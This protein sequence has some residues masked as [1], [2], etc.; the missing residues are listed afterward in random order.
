MPMLIVVGL[1]GGAGV[2]PG[3]VNCLLPQLEE[4][5]MRT[6]PLAS[7]LLAGVALAT[8]AAAI[9]PLATDA[10][11]HVAARRWAPPGAAAGP[12]A[13]ESGPP[14]WVSLGPFGGNVLAVATSPA[15]SGLVLAAVD[16]SGGGS[17]LYRSTDGGESWQPVTGLGFIFV[18]DVEFAADGT[19][20][21]A[22]SSHLQTSVDGGLNWSPITNPFNGSV[23][24]VAFEPA[25][26]ALWLGLG[27]ATFGATTFVIRSPDGGD[28]WADRTP[29]LPT[30]LDCTALALEPG[31]PATVYAG[32]SGF[33]G[34][35]ALWV[36]PD[37][38]VT[39]FDRTAGL[40]AV[41]IHRI[42]YDGARAVVAGGA[43]FGSQ[44]FGLYASDDDGMSW[45]PLH[46]GTWP[47]LYTFGLDIDPN[48]PSVL[49]VATATAGIFRSVDGGAEWAFGVAGTAGVSFNAVRYAP[50][51]SSLVLAGA[52][53]QGVFRSADGGAGF[54]PSS[55]GI[56]AV[57]VQ[58]VAAHPAD[59]QQLAAAFSGLNDGGVFT[60]DDGGATWV[61]EPVPPTRYS[62]VE[63]APGGTLYAIS[64]GPSSVAPE[65]VYRRESGGTWTPLGPNQGPFFETE[66]VALRFSAADP[67][68]ILLA[69]NDF[70]VA[71]FEATI[72]RSLNGGAGWSKVHE[73]AATGS[74]SGVEILR[75]G[76]DQTMV[77]AYLGFDSNSGGVL[78]STNG[79]TTWSPSPTGLPAEVHGFGL[80][81]SPADPL[82]LFYA[83]GFLP[84]GLFGS[85]DG[86][87][88]WSSAGPFAADLRGVACDGV[89]E[90]VLWVI[91]VFGDGVV[92]R[93]SDSGLS[94]EPFGTGLPP[95]TALHQLVWA[96]NPS[97]L[98]LASGAGV[99][100]HDLPGLFA[101][102][103]E[104]G[105]TSAW[106][107]SIG[108]S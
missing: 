103:F 20:Y 95:L 24:E 92:L 65:G 74:V 45:T 84:T 81:A 41:P 94:F 18:S 102:G 51:S 96:K 25:T 56:T 88:S 12:G 90:G 5:V 62:F 46:D 9:E 36:S 26:G 21:L 61:S 53:S 106:S 107:A 66:G 37:Q 35:G 42:V 11:G 63:F 13:T 52:T 48:D 108:G 73:A 28:T 38:G 8:P 101:D 32:F 75:G 40:P 98:F 87:V 44:T 17:P 69:G 105:D 100:R 60:S 80:C 19:A 71:G 58:S 97:R 39:W 50:G 29:P 55:T 6:L 14:A 15:V 93:S 78:R 70:G 7:L 82:R 2:L 22:T 33:P 49:L 1:S 86:G 27:G 34:G 99:W 47:S 23:I 91:D 4:A 57:D 104:S 59:P 68:L 83:S 85:A 43:Q 10:H 31:S 67:L 72:W 76:N 3:P 54:A 77:A 79:G 30:P 16:S 89:E 64:D